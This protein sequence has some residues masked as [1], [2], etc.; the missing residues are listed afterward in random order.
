[1]TER[2]D[3]GRDDGATRKG[4]TDPGSSTDQGSQAR[5]P[6]PSPKAQ[7]A[8]RARRIGGRP[9]PGAA[10]RPAP[11]PTPGPMPG[12]E[13][14]LA[15]RAEPAEPAERAERAETS[16]AVVLDKSQPPAARPHRPLPAWLSWLPSAVLAAVLVL[17]LVLGVAASHGVWWATKSVN[18]A[19]QRGQVLAAAKSCMATMNTYDYRKLDQAEAKG[20]AC[21]TGKFTAQYKTAIDKLVRPQATKLKFTQAATVNNAGI[22]SVSSDGKQWVVLIFGQ[23]STTNSA[24]GTSTPKLSIFSARV[25]MQPVSGHWLVASYEYA[26][27]G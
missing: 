14:R 23:L 16:A 7:A 27:S 20:L 15:P 2:D 3:E 11:G 5:R 19:T 1:M 6:A 18:V 8:S 12:P 22:E 4:S 24:D 9:Q 26:P 13:S 17:V 10:S 21:T 25:T